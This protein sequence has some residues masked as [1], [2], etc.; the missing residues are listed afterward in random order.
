MA[1]QCASI[2]KALVLAC[3]WFLSARVP[4][5]EG[6][7]FYDEVV[8]TRKAWSSYKLSFPLDKMPGKLGLEGPAYSS[9]IGPFEKDFYKQQID[10]NKA[11]RYVLELSEMVHWF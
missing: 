10:R 11:A 6:G 2:L 7:L 9:L 5:V 8:W 3:S 4:P 1:R